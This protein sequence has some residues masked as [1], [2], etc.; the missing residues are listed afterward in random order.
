MS[1]PSR[2]ASV[3]CCVSSVTGHSQQLARGAGEPRNEFQG[4]RSPILTR[5]LRWVTSANMS[6]SR[7]PAHSASRIIRRSPRAHRTRP[8]TASRSRL[9]T[10]LQALGLAG[11]FLRESRRERVTLHTL[12]LAPCTLHLA[13][14]TLHLAHP[15]DLDGSHVQLRRVDVQPCR[16][17]APPRDASISV[18][19]RRSAHRPHH[20]PVDI[21]TGAPVDQHLC[22][23]SLGMR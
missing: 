9:L 14:C 23:T 8:I 1:N 22:A 12:H 2:A 17:C 7:P 5:S 13:P 6:G 21:E 18:G 3:M 11:S 20:L 10:P 16:T 15:A 4:R 19:H